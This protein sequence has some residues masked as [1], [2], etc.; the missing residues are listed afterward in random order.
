MEK[1]LLQQQEQRELEMHNLGIKNL[2]RAL[3]EAENRMYASHTFYG[4][5]AT[6][7]VL[8]DLVRRLGTELKK[9]VKGKTGESSAVLSRRLMGVRAEPLIY[10]TVMTLFDCAGVQKRY[11]KIGDD[12]DQEETRKTVAEVENILGKRLESE[13][14]FQ[15]FKKASKGAYRQLRGLVFTAHVGTEQKVDNMY[16]AMRKR[17]EYYTKVLSEEIQ[18]DWLK[19]A[20]DERRANILSS[21]KDV[22]KLMEN[23]RWSEVDRISIAQ[24]F[25]KH[26]KDALYGWF[27]ETKAQ[28]DPSTSTKVKYL[29]F[30]H[31]F[32]KERYHL[33]EQAKAFS[34]FNLPMLCPPA[35]WGDGLY[36]G[37]QKNELDHQH[38]FVR[39]YGEKSEIS[40]TTYDFING[41]QKVAFTLNPFVVGVQRWMREKGRYIDDDSFKVYLR[42]S[43]A[44]FP[45]L[46][47][48]LKLPIKIEEHHQ[49]QELEELKAKKAE[50]RR[51]KDSIRDFHTRLRELEAA[52]RPTNRYFQTIDLIKDDPAFYFPWSVCSRTRCYPLTDSFSPQGP[53][54]QK[55]A[56]AYAVP[57]PLDEE[58]EYW[59]KVMLATAA[60]YGK[61]SFD[62]RASIGS[63]LIDTGKVK[64]VATDPT[65][66]GYDVWTK[67]D[68]PWIFLA[69]AKEVWDCFLCPKSDRKTGTTLYCSGIDGTASGLQILGGL[70]RDLKTCQLVNCV[71]TDQPS[72]VYKAVL[73]KTIELIQQDEHQPSVFPSF[74]PVAKIAGK[75]KL[76]KLSCMTK[77]YAAGHDTRVKQVTEVLEQM[78]IKLFA[79]VPPGANKV[80]INKAAIDYLVTKIE[81]AIAVL[82]PGAD[83]ILGWFL[84]VS[85][86]IY[87]SGGSLIR[88]P[89]AS[90]NIVVHDYR[91]P[92]YS[93]KQTMA[94]G[95]YSAKSKRTRKLAD[96][97]ED[98]ADV[99]SGVRALGANLT[100]AC[101]AAVLQLA[102]HDYEGNY[103]TNHDAVYL[104]C[105]K[106]ITIVQERLQRAYKQM[107]EHNVL[108]QLLVA[109]SLEGEGLEPPMKDTYD[110]ECGLKA[111]YLFC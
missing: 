31:A 1:S 38:G 110:P 9:R 101:D 64:A 78:G 15:K 106:Q 74:F 105:S 10:I 45:Q 2:Q 8:P 39:G 96:G 108:E 48:H 19:D 70:T 90:G 30:G 62:S 4:L 83:Q 68:E 43:D 65:G 14:I 23:P 18:P 12:A 7:S 27:V 79:R 60:G 37:Y 20:D 29:E 16:R 99:E 13:A 61:E 97:F 54:Y 84:D 85:R 73:D 71:P 86:H 41:Q 47:E 6:K 100:H 94:Y 66:S 44:D 55:A 24:W 87:E 36:G 34:F 109:N 46:P 21:M 111:N 72:D 75:R 95:S 51:E 57:T 91:F 82:I 67:M 88:I 35:D 40:Q 49:G 5:K 53:E 77:A 50:R 93:V 104:P 42:P 33:I 89:T 76:T 17:A 52:A 92:T 56:L 58:S 25:M 103:G 69:T 28:Y 98:N 32:A 11:S 59:M 22:I 26:T 63:R 102:L 107:V 80:E 81:D 3:S